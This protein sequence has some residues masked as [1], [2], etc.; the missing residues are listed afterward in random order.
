MLKAVRASAMDMQSVA[1]A[2]DIG[3]YVAKHLADGEFP[4]VIGGN[5]SVL[6][7]CLVGAGTFDQV[8]QIHVDGHSDFFHPGNYDTQSRLGSAAGMDLAL[9]TGRVEKLLTQWP[10]IDRSPVRDENVAQIGERDALRPE[11]TRYY[12]DI[13]DTS[14]NR[15]IVQDIFREEVPSISEMI[16]HWAFR[17]DVSQSW[18]HV[19]KEQ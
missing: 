2:I 6:L 3:E 12:G 14:I 1:T 4:I 16:A 5:C 15:V 18:L 17:L 13:R 7:G 8:G 10:G 11:Y 19:D 9:A